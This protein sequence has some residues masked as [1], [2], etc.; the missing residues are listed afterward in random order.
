[1]WTWLMALPA[2]WQVILVIL[3]LVSVVVV[4]IWGKAAIKWGSNTFGF[5]GRP[6]V[7]DERKR[8]R[9]CGDCVL[10]LI[11][12]R[13]KCQIDVDHI[14]KSVLK[15]QMN[16]AEQ[17]L[18]ELQNRLLQLYQMDMAHFRNENTSATE[19]N[20]QFKAYSGWLNTVFMMLKDEIR[21]TFKENHFE[22]LNGNDFTLYC[23]SKFNALFAMARSCMNIQY[24]YEGLIVPTEYKNERMDKMSNELHLMCKQTLEYA[25][26]VK[27]DGIK[28]VKNMHEEY[29]KDIDTFVGE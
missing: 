15:D 1:M 17:R 21:R 3:L 14:E 11:G 18:I 24:P 9:S 7:K 27:R 8:K 2:G 10:I 28:K 12:M 26:D 6:R 19:E 13:D 25:R 16:Y 5:G 29:K 4:S 23:E 22:S 20:K